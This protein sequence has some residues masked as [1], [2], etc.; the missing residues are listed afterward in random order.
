MDTSIGAVR[1]KQVYVD[2]LDGFGM[3]Y[4]A[5]YATFFD[6]AVLDYWLEAGWAVDPSAS[7]QVIR[8]LSLTYHAPVLGAGA[9]DVH[10]WIGR[11]GRTSVQYDFALLSPDHSVVHAEGSRT[12]VNLDPQTLR[13]TPLTDEM[14]GYAAPLLAP[15]VM[16]P[17]AA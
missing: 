7:V 8:Q 13:P 9:V 12:L 4:H 3:L 11:A 10:F 15:G 2:D 16:R 6:H 1:R 14:W 17:E 5:A